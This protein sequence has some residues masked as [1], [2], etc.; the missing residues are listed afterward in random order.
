M[1]IIDRTCLSYWFPLIRDAGVRVPKTEIVTTD[2]EVWRLACG[3][4]APDGY[5]KFM[6]EL[7]EA[8]SSIGYPCFLRTGH[9]SNK[10]DWTRTCYLES[11]GNLP[12]HVCELAEFSECCDLVGLPTNV[13]VVRELIPTTPAF[14][15]FRGM[16]IVR[17][18]R[19]FTKDYKAVCMHPYWPQDAIRNPD[20]VD[21]AAKLAIM[22]TIGTDT[23]LLL[24]AGAE[25]AA[26][27]TSHGDWSVDLLQDSSK[28]WW[29]TDMAE[30]ERS[31]HH[32]ECKR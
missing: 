1:S 2:C 26:K 15:A 32:P 8:A 6:A 28:G 4:T 31:F 21:W 10:H 17:E 9:T 16:P 14:H 20:A 29:L 19:V 18:F 27:A 3:N 23:K 25:E 11:D 5:A 12:H 30:A 7:R 13:W 22:S 24:M